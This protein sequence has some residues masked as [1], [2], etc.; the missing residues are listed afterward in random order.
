[1]QVFSDYYRI[2]QVHHEASQEV[3]EAAYKRLCRIYHPDIN[4]SL[5]SGERMQEINEAHDVLCDFARRR[6]YHREWAAMSARSG[7]RQPFTPPRREAPQQD[8]ATDARQ[9]LDG[10]FHCLMDGQWDAAYAMLTSADRRNVPQEDFR[11]WKNAVA[12]S[13]RIGS[14][15]IKPFRRYSNCTVAGAFYREV[16]EFSVF[17][18][19]MD[20]SGHVSEQNY[21]KYV[22][23]DAGAWRVCLGYADLKPLILRFK[24]MAENQS[25]LDPNEVYAEAVLNHDSQTGLLSRR[26]FLEK[27][28]KEAVRSRRYGNVFTA[29]LIIVYPGSEPPGFNC[30]EYGR[31]CV[32]HAARSIAPVLRKTDIL[33]RWGE[34]E[35]AILFTE[36]PREN[37]GFAMEKLT[38]RLGQPEEIHYSVAYGL[39]EFDGMQLEDTMAEAA[40][41][42]QVRRSTSGGVTSTVITIND[43]S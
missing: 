27:A 40:S 11:E 4:P 10:Y 3:I 26:G 33:A 7:V 20:A 17:V 9:A 32:A 35:L 37:A 30:G 28:E 23:L 8:P 21:L 2:L 31:M 36:T 18:C 41:A 29:G 1:M 12:G 43:Y 6:A 34:T 13:Y 25:P 39:S 14:W 22:A 42:A 5:R 16:H 19:D 24:Y 15:A 38:D